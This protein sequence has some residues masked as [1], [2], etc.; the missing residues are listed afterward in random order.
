MRSGDGT[1]ASA[2][3][4]AGKVESVG[5]RSG[6]E[7]LWWVGKGLREARAM[8]GISVFRVVEGVTSIEKTRPAALKSPD[9]DLVRMR[10]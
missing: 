5:K 1:K 9:I 8:A 4:C 10:G 3:F 2:P 6:R 7:K